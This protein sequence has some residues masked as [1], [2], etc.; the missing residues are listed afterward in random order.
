MYAGV[1]MLASVL[2][3]IDC[4]TKVPSSPCFIFMWCRLCARSLVTGLVTGSGMPAVLCVCL[5][6]AN[7]ALIAECVGVG[8]AVWIVCRC[9]YV[10]GY[11][12][13]SNN[14]WW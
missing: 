6:Q 2:Q 13:H 3:V 7:F 11:C 4:K 1:S 9:S 12:G 10:A 8:G 14:S 5:Q